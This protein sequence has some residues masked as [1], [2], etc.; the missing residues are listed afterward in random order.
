MT[1]KTITQQIA[2]QI[3]EQTFYLGEDIPEGFVLT[4]GVNRR[5]EYKLLRHDVMTHRFTEHHRFYWGS[6]CATCGKPFV[7]NTPVEFTLMTRNCDEHRYEP[8]EDA[9]ARAR[10]ERERGWVWETVTLRHDANGD[11]VTTVRRIRIHADLKA[12]IAASSVR[13]HMIA[14]MG[15]VERLI[16][17][18]VEEDY[19]RV[20]SA[21]YEDFIKAVVGRMD[22]PG[23]GQRDTRRQIARQALKNLSD[24]MYPLFSTEKGRVYFQLY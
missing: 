10:L 17:K 2:E 22:A 21:F 24:G 8:V 14:R 6:D 3:S 12:D 23:E 19:P 5:Q 16:M 18:T 11:P 13:Q 4:I 7:S 15:A 20:G 9:D 1:E